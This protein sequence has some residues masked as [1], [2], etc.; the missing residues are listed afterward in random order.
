MLFSRIF[1]LSNSC[2]GSPPFF[3][4]PGH[5]SNISK[6]MKNRIIHGQYSLRETC[7]QN[8]SKEAKDLIKKMLETNPE[9]RLSIDELINSSWINVNKLFIK[10]KKLKK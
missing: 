2:S 4:S 10:N 8:V 7:W 5:R 9:H 3:V 6:G 1:N